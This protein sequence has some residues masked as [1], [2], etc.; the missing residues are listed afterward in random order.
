MAPPHHTHLSVISV[1]EMLCSQITYESHSKASEWQHEVEVIFHA[2]F[3]PTAMYWV[4]VQCPLHFYSMKD[5]ALL[6]F[7]LSVVG[8]IFHWNIHFIETSFSSAFVLI[9]SWHIIVFADVH[10]A[11]CCQQLQYSVSIQSVCCF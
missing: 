8:F 5:Q 1:S 11:E 4:T 7:F 10:S 3:F 9:S 2:V 6:V